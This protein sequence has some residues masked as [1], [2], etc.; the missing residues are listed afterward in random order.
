MVEVKKATTA[1]CECKTEL[2][3]AGLVLR[4]MGEA[5]VC[6]AGAGVEGDV[7][8]GV[9]SWNW[10]GLALEA[11]RDA[12]AWRRVD[13]KSG[14]DAGGAPAGGIA[15]ATG[16]RYMLSIVGRRAAPNG[17]DRKSV[18]RSEYCVNTI[19]VCYSQNEYKITFNEVGY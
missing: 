11:A 1:R 19:K 4:W 16:R 14:L 2:K 3:E 12:T 8:A 6:V 10:L 17:V 7:G 5:S 13:A 15:P 18:G 9:G